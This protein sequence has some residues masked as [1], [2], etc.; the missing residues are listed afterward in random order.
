MLLNL[1]NTGVTKAGYLLK[2]CSESEWRLYLVLLNDHCISY[3]S[4]KQNFKYPERNIL[5]SASTRVY[6]D[7]EETVMRIETGLDV[8]LFRGK[9]ETEI[10]EWQR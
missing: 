9:D 7:E 8:L 10:K 1:A 5:L 2:C 6:K 3:C 4:E